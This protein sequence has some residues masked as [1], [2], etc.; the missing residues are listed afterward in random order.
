LGDFENG[1]KAAEGITVM[2]VKH[3]DSVMAIPV[4]LLFSLF[5]DRYINK[6]QKEQPGISNFRTFQVKSSNSKQCRDK[7]T[8]KS[9]KPRQ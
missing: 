3:K 4:R 2:D 5:P 9:G 1:I 7:V 8:T 6:N